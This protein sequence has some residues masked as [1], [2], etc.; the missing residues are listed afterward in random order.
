M[1]MYFAAMRCPD[2]P[3]WI[4][5]DDRIDAVVS[6][7]GRPLKHAE[8]RLSS[9]NQEYRAI[10]DRGGA[11]LIPNVAVGSYSFRV[12]GWGEA[13]LE[14]KGWHRRAI[15]RPVLFFSSGDGCQFLTKV[16]N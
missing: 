4:V 13:H 9:S 3:S 1:L 12:Q 10:T 16:S 5:D 11:F 15:N 8:V 7:K 14:V 6:V 2:N